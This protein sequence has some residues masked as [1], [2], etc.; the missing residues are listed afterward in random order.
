MNFDKEKMI[1]AI[2]STV[3]PKFLDMNLAAF[4]KGYEI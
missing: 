3:P 1:E 2:K 4:E